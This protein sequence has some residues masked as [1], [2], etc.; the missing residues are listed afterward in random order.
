MCNNH[1][2]IEDSL[3]SGFRHTAE[4]EQILHGIAHSEEA[5]LRMRRFV[6]LDNRSPGEQQ[7]DE[8]LRDD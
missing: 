1:A 3:S 5:G 2:Y 4:N 7:E 6:V 8:E